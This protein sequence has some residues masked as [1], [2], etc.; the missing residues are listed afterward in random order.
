MNIAAI[1]WR[2]AMDKP[3]REYNVFSKHNEKKAKKK[4]AEG[5]NNIKFLEIFTF[6]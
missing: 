1:N 3:K 5:I 4:K 2:Q 6:R